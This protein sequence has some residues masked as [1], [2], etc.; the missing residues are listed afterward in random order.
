MSLASLL[1]AVMSWTFFTGVTKSQLL[2]QIVAPRP[3]VK[4]HDH[5]RVGNNLWVLEEHD[6]DT[7]IVYYQVCQEMNVWGY[8]IWEEGTAPLN[9][10]LFFLDLAPV[11]DRKWRQRVREYH[12]NHNR[13]PEPKEVWSLKQRTIPHITV[14]QVKGRTIVGTYLG[15]EYSGPITHLGKRLRSWGVPASLVNH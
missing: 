3:G 10:P 9:C 5:V 13:I 6:K 4:I 7:E 15:V 12:A 1:S 14:T 8:Q 11:I 2:N